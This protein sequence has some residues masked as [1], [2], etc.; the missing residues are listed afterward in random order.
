MNFSKI[1]YEKVEKLLVLYNQ[2]CKIKTG[3]VIFAIFDKIVTGILRNPL[4]FRVKEI[5][6]ETIVGCMLCDIARWEHFPAA[7]QIRRIFCWERKNQ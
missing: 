7:G 1:Y 3:L 4:L 6:Y 2:V 5:L